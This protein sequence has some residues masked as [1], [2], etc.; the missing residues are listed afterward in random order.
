MVWP[1]P[2][3]FLTGFLPTIMVFWPIG[4]VEIMTYT[5]ARERRNIHRICYRK[6]QRD[7]STVC[8]FGDGTVASQTVY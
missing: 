8:C 2:S 6:Y 7:E 5:P 1:S 3:A 4:L